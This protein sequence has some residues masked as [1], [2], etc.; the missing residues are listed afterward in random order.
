MRSCMDTSPLTRSERLEYEETLRLLACLIFE[1]QVNW[2]EKVDDEPPGNIFGRLEAIIEHAP[3]AVLPLVEHLRQNPPKNEQARFTPTRFLSFSGNVLS[4]AGHK[5][6][7]MRCKVRRRQTG[8]KPG[9][10]L[11]PAVLSTCPPG[12]LSPIRLEI[13]R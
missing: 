1:I 4:T 8:T 7:P 3:P 6:M 10:N 12:R 9:T 2:T 13:C 5:Y 11:R